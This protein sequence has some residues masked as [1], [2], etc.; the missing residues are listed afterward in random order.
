[1][2]RTQFSL[3]PNGRGAKNDDTVKI[4]ELLINVVIFNKRKAM[5][6]LEP[7]GKRYGQDV[8]LSPCAD[9][10]SSGEQ[11]EPKSSS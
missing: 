5:I 4:F 7:K 1:M 8:R 2:S 6:T 11:A 3:V 9:K 10:N